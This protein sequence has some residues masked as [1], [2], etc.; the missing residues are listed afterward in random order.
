MKLKRFHIALGI[1]LGILL[2]LLFIGSKEHFVTGESY[3]SEKNRCTKQGCTITEGTD[4]CDRNRTVQASFF[5]NDP[6]W[7]KIL[8]GKTI[9]VCASKSGGV[10]PYNECSKCSSCGSIAPPTG[11]T[12]KSICVPLTS[13]G[14]LAFDAP[15]ELTDLLDKDPGSI[16]CCGI[17]DETTST[18][19]ASSTTPAAH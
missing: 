13:S 2:V 9:S 5:A 14:C 1:T 6:D 17:K 10:I 4:T 3:C 19:E 7:G 8:G 16:K 18:P 12:W 15:K 11:N